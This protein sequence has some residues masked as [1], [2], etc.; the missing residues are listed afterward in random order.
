[1]SIYT[2]NVQNYDNFHTSERFSVLYTLLSVAGAMRLPGPLEPT[3]DSPS[4]FLTDFYIDKFKLP[5]K[6]FVNESKNTF[7]Y[8]YEDE[9]ITFKD[10]EKNPEKYCTKYWPNWDRKL[11]KETKRLY[12]I[13]GLKS[14]FTATIK[15]IVDELYKDTSKLGWDMWVKKWSFFSVN[16]LLRHRK[17]DILE[18]FH[19][20]GIPVDPAEELNVFDRF[21]PWPEQAIIGYSTLEYDI[22]LDTSLVVYLSDGLGQWLKDPM[23]TLEGGLSTLPW[24]FLQKLHS[25]KKDIVDLSNKIRFGVSVNRIEYRS[26]SVTVHG[27]NKTS[28]QAYQFPG[29]AVIIT[30][31]LN[32]V[33]QLTFDPPLPMR[34]Y[35]GF[36]HIH[37]GYATKIMIQSRRSFWREEGIDGGFSITNMPIGQI[38][39]P[40]NSAHPVS[41]ADERGILLCY[42]WRQDALLFGSQPK[43]NAIKEAVKEIS[44]VHCRLTDKEFFEVGSIQAWYNDPSAQGPYAQLT[45]NQYR[46]VLRLMMRPHKTVYLA[47]EALSYTSGWIQGA[48]EAGLRAAFQFYKENES[49]CSERHTSTAASEL[50]SWAV[51]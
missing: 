4:H 48:I 34:Y 3:A 29:D 30:L 51:Y 43:D 18:D 42:M 23:H 35:D 32:I 45:P 13:R 44:K 49:R 10:W 38:H 20:R 33:R 47:G 22:D 11:T 28:L 7:Y 25:W 19:R 15:P 1:M 8:F 16:T 17:K 6:H 46:H 37:Y 24:H 9:K 36:A 39:Y 40:S 26:N 21:L 5:K 50:K 12:N 31:P 14:Y 41:K 27:Y 2:G